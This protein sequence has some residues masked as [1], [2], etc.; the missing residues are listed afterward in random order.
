MNLDDQNHLRAID[1]DDML[2]HID[3]LA[4]QF[5]HAWQRALTLPL[6]ETHRA[7]RQIALAGMG[8]SAIGGDLTAALVAATSPAAF[9]VVR[10]YT[11]PAYVR[12]ADTLVI[13]SSHSGNTEETLA[14]ADQAL[15]RGVRMLAIS[16]GGALAEHAA[17]HGYPLWQFDYASQPRAALGWSFG[18]LIGLAHRLGL[19]PNLEA[20]LREGVGLL[21]AQRAVYGAASPLRDNPAK[22]GAGQLIDRIPLI[23]GAGI[24]E[25]VARR[26]KGQFNEN[27]KVHAFA[28]ALPEQNHNEILGWTRASQQSSIWSVVYLRDPQETEDQPRIAR[29]IA[30]LQAVIASSA[31]QHEVWATGD[32][33][34]ERLLG[35]LYYG[36]FVSV[37]AALLAGVDPTDIAGIDLL[38]GEMANL[39]GNGR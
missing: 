4:D 18:L 31:E 1:R 20:D 17:R 8:G 24:F 26:W 30:V 27:A 2:G 25:P 3:A 29:R 23:F 19:A 39:N 5:E 15:E 11:L 9:H 16:T 33:L 12:G 36:D 32:S 10:G 34:M 6:P 38:K 14:A 13:A 28:N 35:T 22:R 37:Y 21:R 7:P